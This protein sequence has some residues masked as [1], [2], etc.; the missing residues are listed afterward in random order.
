MKTTIEQRPATTS[1][2]TRTRRP[3]RVVVASADRSSAVRCS[4]SGRTSRPAATPAARMGRGATSNRARSGAN[5]ASA[6]SDAISA[7]ASE[8][9]H[10]QCCD[11]RHQQEP[12]G[13]SVADAPPRVARLQRPDRWIHEPHASLDE[14]RGEDQHYAD[15]PEAHGRLDATGSRYHTGSSIGRLADRTVPRP[16]GLVSVSWPPRASTRSRRP[17]SPVPRPTSAPP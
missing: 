8:R 9:G 14:V 3:D 7:S 15:E 11:P 1:T 13:C 5:Q 12:S 10:G 2:M 17:R 6:A 4:S 16:A